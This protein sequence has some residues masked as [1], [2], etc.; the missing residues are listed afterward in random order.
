MGKSKRRSLTLG[1]NKKLTKLTREEA[2]EI[3]LKVIEDKD[4]ALE[5]ITLFGLGAEE[6]LEAGATYEDV[7]A[8]GNMIE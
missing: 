5:M 3:T 6:L 2:I 7:M 1:I 8:F 4:E